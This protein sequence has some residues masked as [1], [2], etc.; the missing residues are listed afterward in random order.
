MLWILADLWEAMRPASMIVDCG[1]KTVQ[2]EMSIYLN[3][4]LPVP[5]PCV[6]VCIYIY[7]LFNIGSIVL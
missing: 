5:D 3:S 1:G 7:I 4:S 6:Y 2:K